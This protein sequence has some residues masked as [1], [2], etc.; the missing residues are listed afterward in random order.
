M[1][2]LPKALSTAERERVLASTPLSPTLNLLSSMPLVRN[3]LRDVHTAAA[4]FD[5]LMQR[6]SLS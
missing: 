6:C 4:A 2:S 3:R 5:I 1:R